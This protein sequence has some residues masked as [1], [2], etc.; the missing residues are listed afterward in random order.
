MCCG[1]SCVKTAREAMTDPIDQTLSHRRPLPSAKTAQSPYLVIAYACEDP[2]FQPMRIALDDVDVIS[3]G[4]GTETK[5][6]RTS[7]GDIRK[8]DVRLPD[9]WMSTRHAE[10]FRALDQ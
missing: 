4:R 5:I 7:D 8:L 9:H 10:L 1:K 3:F 6:E 2:G